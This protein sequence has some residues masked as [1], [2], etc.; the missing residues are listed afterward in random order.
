[1]QKYYDQ[2]I[3]EKRFLDNLSKRTLKYYGW[4]FNRWTD[5]VG[6]MPDKQNIK[7]FVIKIQESGVTVYTANSYIRG[8]NSFLSWLAE[9]DHCEPLKIKKLKEPE[10]VLNV[11]IRNLI[12]LLNKL[13]MRKLRSYLHSPKGSNCK[14]RFYWFIKA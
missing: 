5:Y 7:E 14:G 12:Q 6:T 9:N 1:M 10:K 13:S 2:F 11:E 4:V 8:I 3:K